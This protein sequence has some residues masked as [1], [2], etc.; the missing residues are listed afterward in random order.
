MAPNNKQLFFLS[1]WR[2]GWGTIVTF[3]ANVLH[4]F[5]P[6]PKILHDFVPSKKNA[7]FRPWQFFFFARFQLVPKKCFPGDE[8]VQ[9]I[10]AYATHCQTYESTIL[11]Q[12]LCCSLRS[13]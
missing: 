4:D 12:M 2:L 5:V 7:R 6:S 13:S 3:G 1:F 9:F 8:I 11:K 10:F